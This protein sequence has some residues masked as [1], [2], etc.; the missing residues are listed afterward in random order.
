[1]INSN[2]IEEFKPKSGNGINY[3]FIISEIEQPDSICNQ[4]SIV[5]TLN[6]I[7]LPLSYIN[8]KDNTLTKKFTI[9]SN[10]N[11]D[12]NGN[13]FSKLIGYTNTIN[14]KPPEKEEIFREIEIVQTKLQKEIEID[15]V[16]VYSQIP[17]VIINI[18]K[19]YESLYRTYSTEYK[20]DR[21]K[22]IGVK[23][24]FNNLKTKTKYPDININIIGNIIVST[25]FNEFN[26]EI[27]QEMEI[28]KNE[29]NSNENNQPTE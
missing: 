5:F 19:E 26:S 27:S 23:I 17:S 4:D 18:D 24:I 21:D 7:N 15:F 20:K 13:Y 22:Y 11:L 1:M 25:K 16:N 6:K 28:I 14:E 12:K 9:T 2:L 8:P 3:F 10:V 29:P